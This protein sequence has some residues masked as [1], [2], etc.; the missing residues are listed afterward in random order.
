MVAF[1]RKVSIILLS[2]ALLVVEA[3]ASPSGLSHY[4]SSPISHVSREART[5]FGHAG[6][7][8]GARHSQRNS[9]LLSSTTT[10]QESALDVT[11]QVVSN[12]RG[13]GILTHEQ[14]QE[15]IDGAY[16]W[17][18]NLGA[19]SALVAG[20]VV[21]TLYE[22]MHSGDLEVVETDTR[23]VQAGKK[24]TRL[25]L[26]SA[27]ALETLSI[28]VTTVTGTMLLSRTPDQMNL[29][30]T[31]IHTPLDF[32]RENFEFEYLTA[33]ITFLQ[34]LLNW[35]AAIG[36][37]HIL[38]S[39]GDVVTPSEVAVNHFIACSMGTLIVLMISFFN[40][41]MTHYKNYGSMLA[42]WVYVTLHGHFFLDWPP[43]PLSFLLV[44]SLFGSLYW[45]YK[46]LT[47]KET[48]VVS[49]KKWMPTG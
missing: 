1:P 25:L 34:G 12:L 8:R 7:H 20:A 11:C 39:P 46:T 19:P 18:C 40:T 24:V 37:A 3:K 16:G 28:F 38:P 45:G 17:C 29:S 32:L 48:E 2:L 6:R 4:H 15:F 26:L 33:R 44:P 47:L 49:K 30:D 5:V 42:R 27:F 43:R 35:L 41:H 13:G 22:N 31:I 23:S 9:A 14:Y 21:A 36:L 10:I